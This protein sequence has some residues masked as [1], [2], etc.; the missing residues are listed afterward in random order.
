LDYF[1]FALVGL[2]LQ[3][4]MCETKELPAVVWVHIRVLSMPDGFSIAQDYEFD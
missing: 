1:N 3:G 4:I 2:V